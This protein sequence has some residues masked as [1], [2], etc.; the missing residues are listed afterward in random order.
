[1][2]IQKDTV[3]TIT[4]KLSEAGGPLLEASD[5][6]IPMAYLHGHNNILAGLEEALEGQETGHET[7]VTLAPENAYGPVHANA[8]QKVPVKHLVGKHKRLLPG[9]FVK[10][11][12]DNGTRDARVVKAGK[13]MVTL[14]TNHPFAGKTLVFDVVV[15]DVR[16]ATPD[17]IAHGHAH[18]LGGHN[19]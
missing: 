14:D 19:H 5:D 1:M 6:A 9:M 2:K 16:E 18:G 10:V 12:T 13:F 8:E 3:A 4:Y 7:S 17:E 15:R 11:N